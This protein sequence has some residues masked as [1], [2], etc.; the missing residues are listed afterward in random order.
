MNDVK[1]VICKLRNG[2]TIA[3]I[4]SHCDLFKIELVVRAGMLDETVEQIGFAHFIEHLMSFF[5]SSEYPNSEKNQQSLDLYS[6]KSNA[7]TGENSAG[8]Y[9]EG[10]INHF[11]TV[12]DL[13]F[14]NY[15]N[16][17][18]SEEIFDQEKHAV[19]RELEGM[20]EDLWYN[21]DHMIQMVDYKNTILEYSLYEEI[22]NVDKNATVKNILE[23][24]K[25]FYRPENT[26]VI[27]TAQLDNFRDICGAI[28][29]LYFG[30]SFGSFWDYFKPKPKHTNIQFEPESKAK[31]KNYDKF[32]YFFIKPPQETDTFS[33]RIHFPIPF[34]QF[35]DRFYTIDFINMILSQSM[36]SRLYYALRTKL[37]AIYNVSTEYHFDP[38]N[39]KYNR[40]IIDF[41]TNSDKVLNAVDYIMIELMML[42]EDSKLS[43]E[44]SI[45]K[46]NQIKLAKASNRCNYNFHKL[47]TIY[48]DHIIWNKR[49]FVTINEILEKRE[50]VTEK[51]IIKISRSIFKPDKMKV[52][53]S[54]NKPILETE[55]TKNIHLTFN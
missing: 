49:P 54:G 7:W 24:R 12:L 46:Q 19:I 1:P 33:I 11:Y 22:K 5:P 53:Y 30:N 3:H 48:E 2:M 35:D 15:I 52:F 20:T 4:P 23:Y 14:Q 43:K 27:I 42:T 6:L 34:D 40:F 26:V 16:P 37:G 17:I 38:K 28:E 50:R 47:T 18:L 10:M 51:D 45:Q 41:E 36:G 32:T 29:D 31:D 21:L 44:E 9:I 8:Y 55:K 25:R 13:M 39:K